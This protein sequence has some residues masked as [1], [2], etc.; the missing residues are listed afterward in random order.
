MGSWTLTRRATLPAAPQRS[1]RRSRKQF[2]RYQPRLQS[3]TLRLEPPLIRLTMSHSLHWCFTLISQGETVSQN[4]RRIQGRLRLLLDRLVSARERLTKARRR[5][6]WGR[7]AAHHLLS[8]C[9]NAFILPR[10]LRHPLSITA[11]LLLSRRPQRRPQ[12][13]LSTPFDADP[14]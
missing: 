10:S 13:L 4:F 14:S 8:S 6:E 1:T 3:R 9:K 5:L 2:V 12:S 11:L 7:T